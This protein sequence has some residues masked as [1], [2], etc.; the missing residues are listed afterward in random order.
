MTRR[1]ANLAILTQLATQTLRHP[2]L[3]FHQLLQVL[4]INELEVS[5]A[6]PVVKDKFYEESTETLSKLKR[7]DDYIEDPNSL[8]IFKKLLT[9]QYL[10]LG[11]TIVYTILHIL[12]V[13]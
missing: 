10:F 4:D 9:A 13:V 12:E 5:A 2:Y 3:R 11:A 6:A 8:I 7:R 1:D